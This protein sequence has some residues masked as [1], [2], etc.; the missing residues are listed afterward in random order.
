MSF[1]IFWLGVISAKAKVFSFG[2]EPKMKQMSCW[3]AA[4]FLR[5]C[6]SSTFRF[7]PVILTHKQNARPH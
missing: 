1:A 7:F 3:S 4:S 2:N 6:S 5:W